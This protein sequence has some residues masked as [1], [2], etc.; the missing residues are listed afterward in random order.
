MLGH[1]L[2]QILGA[3]F[4]IYTLI[5]GDFR[6]LENF[7]LLKSERIFDNTDVENFPSVEKIIGKLKP[8]F[9]V[10]AAG[11]IKQSA[12]SLNAAKTIEVNSVFP[13]KLAQL[14]ERYEFKLINISTDCVFNGKK[15]NYTEKDIADAEDLYGKSK[16]LG[17]PR[18]TNCLTLRTSIIGRELFTGH[19]LVEW[20]L[21]NAHGEIQGFVNAFFNGFPTVVLADIICEI[22]E[23]QQ[24]LEGVYHISSDPISKY[25][26]LSIIKERYK[27]DIEI[28]P[29]EDFYIDR[30]LDSTKFRKQTGF[31]AL[32]WKEMI[33]KMA[34]DP[35]PYTEWRKQKF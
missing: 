18:R 25:D 4:E 26:L 34:E 33:G 30:S 31:S 13:Q 10:N 20:F 22:I 2:I 1:K 23:K 29:F 16:F 32:S 5:R 3:N 14:A 35:T 9:I 7:G 15:G 8:D 24:R 11:I 12:E 17:E 28:K 19:S 6:R 21:S 27:L